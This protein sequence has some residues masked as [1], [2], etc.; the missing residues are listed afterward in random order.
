MATDPQHRPTER[1]LVDALE[2]VVAGLSE[3]RY[4]AADPAA[5]VTVRPHDVGEALRCPA[6]VAMAGPSPFTPNVATA[7]RAAAIA[8]LDQMVHGEAADPVT[9]YRAAYDEGGRDGFPWEWLTGGDRRHPITPA[10]RAAC[11]MRAIELAAAVARVVP[12]IRARVNRVGERCRWDH[13][14]RPVRLHGRVDLVMGSLRPVGTAE[15]LVV[16]PGSWSPLVRPRLAYEA[17]L[18]TL[19]R[20]RPAT[21]TAVCLAEGRTYSHPVTEDLLGEGVTTTAL[22][23]GAV[24]GGLAK[25]PGQLPRRTGTHCGHCPSAPGCAPGTAWL[26]GP[27][28]RRAGFLVGSGGSGPDEEV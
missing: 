22:A 4:A 6:R 5:R 20:Q 3:G 16:F 23:V 21:V 28:R 17:L 12:D 11:A 14:E 24:A 15:L 7:T 8:V 27:G 2:P 10:E 19:D 26:G 1:A 9:A 18:L 13:P 25:D